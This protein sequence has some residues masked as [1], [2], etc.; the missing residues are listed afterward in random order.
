[1]IAPDGIP[2]SSPV[3]QSTIYVPPA[4]R[5]EF[6]TPPL[7]DNQDASFVT[8]RFD[9]GPVGNVNPFTTLAQIFFGPTPVGAGTVSASAPEPAQPQRFA[10][11]GAQVP[12]T[13]R[14][15]Y[16]S[17]QTIGSNGRCCPRTVR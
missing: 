2:L 4:G 1:V 3:M 5:V 13:T 9:T 12:T 17:E 6:I 8:E 10:G 15:L 11:L 16:F 14:S 7:I